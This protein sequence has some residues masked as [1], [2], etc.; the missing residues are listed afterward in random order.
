MKYARGHAGMFWLMWWLRRNVVGE[1]FSVSV[2]TVN[3]I[4]AKMIEFLDCSSYLRPPS[5]Q[6]AKI[7]LIFFFLRVYPLVVV[8]LNWWMIQLQFVANFNIFLN[9]K[10]KLKWILI[11]MSELTDESPFLLSEWNQALTPAQTMTTGSGT[12]DRSKKSSIKSKWI[13]SLSFVTSEIN[14]IVR[15]T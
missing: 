2:P 8:Q 10:L 14:I 1:F 15:F 11:V 13:K 5:Y 7:F 9:R 4:A 6:I 12:P 3:N